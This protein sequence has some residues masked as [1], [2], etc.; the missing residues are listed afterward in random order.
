[1]NDLDQL[2][3]RANKKEAKLKNEKEMKEVEERE[4]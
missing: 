1:M 3:E 2:K 4:L